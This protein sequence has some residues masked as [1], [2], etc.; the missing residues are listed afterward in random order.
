MHWPS[1]WIR[2]SKPAMNLCQSHPADTA[3]HLQRD[4]GEEGAR[5]TGL[6]R[7]GCHPFLGKIRDLG[8][9]STNEPQLRVKH[10]SFVICAGAAVNLRADKSWR[11]VLRHSRPGPTSKSNY[12]S[13]LLVIVRSTCLGPSTRGL[14]L[15]GRGSFE[16]S[17]LVQ[18]F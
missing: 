6:Q 1:L 16:H 5:R 12:T 15:S 4:Q 13:G 2:F 17:R 10:F 7:S 18:G 14:D 11:G 9:P 3:Q 8:A